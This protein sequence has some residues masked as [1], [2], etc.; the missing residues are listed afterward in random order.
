L[1]DI[2]LMSGAKLAI[3]AAYEDPRPSKYVT[4]RTEIPLVSLPF[5][6]GG[7]PDAMNYIDFY[8]SSVQRLLDG[9]SGRDRP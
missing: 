5:T 8:T 2:V 7:T 3:H 6:V 1:I 9:L 4:D